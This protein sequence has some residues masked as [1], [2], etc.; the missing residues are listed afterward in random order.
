MS[1]L[2]SEYCLQCNSDSLPPWEGNNLRRYCNQ[3]GATDHRPDAAVTEQ[4]VTS[5]QCG[6]GLNHLGERIQWCPT[7][8]PE[9]TRIKRAIRE[10]FVAHLNSP[11]PTWRN[12]QSFFTTLNECTQWA[13]DILTVNCCDTV[14]VFRIEEAFVI[15][16]NGEDFKEATI[17]LAGQTP[18]P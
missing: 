4:Q 14:T 11:D 18:H 7:H 3:C 15:D 9:K 1:K 13:K 2:A 6:C 5:Y 12:R 8:D 16:Y 17:S 10:R